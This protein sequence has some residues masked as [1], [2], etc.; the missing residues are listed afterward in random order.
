MIIIDLAKK[1]EIDK[2][3]AKEYL[4]SGLD[5]M[6]LD[7]GGGRIIQ[8]RPQDQQNILA[9]IDVINGGGSDRFIMKDNTVHSV[10]IAE[11]QQ[12][13]QAGITEGSAHYET[14]M[15]IIQT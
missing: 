10:T 14:Y 4:Q 15:D 3:K 6:D 12:A 2:V 13:L 8:T 7:L 5:S 11:L 1:G 9:K